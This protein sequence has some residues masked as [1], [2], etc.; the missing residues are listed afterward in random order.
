MSDKI[1]NTNVLILIS[2]TS[3]KINLTARHRLEYYNIKSGC[4]NRF[5]KYNT[6]TT[7]PLIDIDDSMAM[8]QTQERIEMKLQYYTKK[9]IWMAP[10]Y[11]AMR[12]RKN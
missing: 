8:T 2:S 12:K 7:S 10:V 3:L 1:R 6:Y 5:E 11:V 4:L 9:P